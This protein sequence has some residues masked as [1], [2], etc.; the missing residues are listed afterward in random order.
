MSA[1][2]FAT[3]TPEERAQ[4]VDGIYNKLS[5]QVA[6][7]INKALNDIRPKISQQVREEIG[8]W[9]VSEKQ[10]RAFLD[11]MMIESAKRAAG[12]F[13]PRWFARIFFRSR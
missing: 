9:A 1:R 10:A 3:L 7:I 6:D 8:K 5:P 13:R 12:F 4:V 2:K 11:G